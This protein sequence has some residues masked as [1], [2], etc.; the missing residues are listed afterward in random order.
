M[1]FFITWNFN[2]N[3]MVF[4]ENVNML[5]LLD[6]LIDDAITITEIYKVDEGG[7]VD[8]T[9]VVDDYIIKM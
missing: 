8:N 3:G 2:H 5:K 4:S 6:R 1:K 9:N 7:N